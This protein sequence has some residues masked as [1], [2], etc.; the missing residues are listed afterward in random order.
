[1]SS[2]TS[3]LALSAGVGIMTSEN[4]DFSTFNHNAATAAYVAATTWDIIDFFRGHTRYV[5]TTDEEGKSVTKQYEVHTFDGLKFT[6]NSVAAIALPLMFFT[7][8]N[9]DIFAIGFVGG[10]VSLTIDLVADLLDS[11]T[12]ILHEINGDKSIFI[13]AF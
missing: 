2:F 10:V 5:T 11:S 13:D 9:S 8:P 4:L 6:A 3:K 1:M 12:E 7:E